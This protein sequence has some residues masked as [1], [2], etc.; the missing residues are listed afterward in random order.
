VTGLLD[1]HVHLWDPALRRY[2]WLDGEPALR[3]AY[4]PTDL[5]VGSVR[6]AG[7]VVV[8]AGCDDPPGEL[9]WIETVAA[10][11]PAIRAVVAHAPLEYGQPVGSVLAGLARRPLVV[12][13]RRNVQ[14]ESPGFMDDPD[15]SAGVRALAPH[16]LTFDACV[17]EHQLTELTR[18]V[19][20]CPE[21]TFVLDHLGKPDIRHHRREP[22]S[23][24]IADLARRPN[25]FAKLSGLTTEADP[26]HWRS[27]DIR[28]YLDHAL[29]VFGPRRCMFGSDWPVATLA[30]TYRRWVDL[31]HQAI[32][33]LSTQDRE[34]VLAGTATRVYRLDDPADG[35]TPA[36]TANTIP[37]P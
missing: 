5:D 28:P 15:F 16:A 33:A 3:R 7:L 20:R 30:T 22:W 32:A 14:D 8:E 9:E 13:V 37:H 6:L 36:P 29:D 18:L 21:V 27:P 23:R 19:D 10:D 2:A 1:S 31:I 24:D 26:D 35:A 17:R 34:D 12:G 11:W 25:V 4:Q